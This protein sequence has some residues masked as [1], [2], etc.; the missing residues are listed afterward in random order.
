[1]SYQFTTMLSSS[2]LQNLTEDELLHLVLELSSVNNDLDKVGISIV[3]LTEY[4][5]GGGM[6]T[7]YFTSS[8]NTSYYP[9]SDY[10]KKF[11]NEFYE[12]Y[13]LLLV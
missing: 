9:L 11:K 13:K 12:K 2:S 5:D 4:G 3:S 10:I 7:M 6:D 1:M 8:I